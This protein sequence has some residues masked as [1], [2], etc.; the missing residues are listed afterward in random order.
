[1]NGK[2]DI[3]NGWD[4]ERLETSLV[5]GAGET[6]ASSRR[7]RTLLSDY[8]VSLTLASREYSTDFIA[9]TPV[10]VLIY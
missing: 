6:C 7:Q 5:V 3:R 1:M 8:G 9:G 2:A 4:C 10:R